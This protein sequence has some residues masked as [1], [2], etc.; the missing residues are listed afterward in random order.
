MKQ[1]SYFFKTDEHVSGLIARI[2]MAIV[3]LPHALQMIFG[4]FGGYGFGSTMNYLTQ[5]EQLPWLVGVMVIM[6]Q[7]VGTLLL[8]FGFM[9]RFFAASMIIL[10]IGMIVTSH[11]HHGFFMNWYGKQEGEGFE[12]HLLVIGLATTVL[13]NGSGSFSL[14]AMLSKVV[15]HRE[16]MP[17]IEFSR[18]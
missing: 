6:L 8:L 5:V 14:D 16:L 10:F 13:L 12:Y 18:L 17:G 9:G 11:A 3:I 7:S 15:R 1:L 2:T 4:W